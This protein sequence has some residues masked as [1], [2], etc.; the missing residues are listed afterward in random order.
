ME[1]DM[2]YKRVLNMKKAAAA[3]IFAL[4][5]LVGGNLYA[6]V[7]CE[8]SASQ[9]YC[10]S[11]YTNPG[12]SA[13]N[14]SPA[15]SPAWTKVSSDEYKVGGGQYIQFQVEKGT[16]YKWSTEGSED[17]FQGTYSAS[18]NTNAQCG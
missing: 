6:A 11:P 10:I 15:F 12:G 18:C 5:P 16:I 8:N 17:L 4:L 2:G 13:Q 14:T 3:L 1:E 7:G 9:T